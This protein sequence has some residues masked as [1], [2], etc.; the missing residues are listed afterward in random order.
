MPALAN[1]SN[2]S[3][4]VTIPAPRPAN[5]AP[6]RSYTSTC[7]PARRNS[8]AAKRPAIEPPITTALGLVRA[9]PRPSFMSSPHFLRLFAESDRDAPYLSFDQ[10][11]H[12]I[13][14]SQR[15]FIN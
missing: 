8:R 6:M 5:S 10:L 2:S 4:W 3:L 13:A 1:T 14:Q 12:V 7:H 9:F 15:L 11:W